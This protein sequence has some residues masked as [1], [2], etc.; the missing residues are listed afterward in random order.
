[1]FY[2]NLAYHAIENTTCNAGE[3][4]LLTVSAKITRYYLRRRQATAG[5][6]KTF[7]GYRKH[8]QTEFREPLKLVN[9]PRVQPLHIRTKNPWILKALSKYSTVFSTLHVFG[10]IVKGNRS[11]EN[12]PHRPKYARYLFLD[13]SHS[14]AD[15][16]AA[17][18]RSYPSC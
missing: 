18:T 12:K 14:I 16:I 10:Y 9:W 5:N 11:G 15:V 6:T 4:Q 2:I 7:A 1:M 13:F 8:R 17:K 3:F